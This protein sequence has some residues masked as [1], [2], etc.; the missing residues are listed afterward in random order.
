MNNILQTISDNLIQIL[1][2]I[3][4]GVISYLGVR[5]KNLYQGYIHDKTKRDIVDKTVR[6]VEQTNKGMSCEDKKELAL[7]KASEWLLERKIPISDT[8]IEILIE[9]A[10][11]CLKEN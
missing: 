9:S 6:Y 3:I 7:K 1:S 2:A 5:I 10:V 4:T 8:E 11:N